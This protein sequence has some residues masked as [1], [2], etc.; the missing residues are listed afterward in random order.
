MKFI[1]LIAILFY[2]GVDFQTKIRPE[3]K[4][5]PFTVTAVPDDLQGAGESYYLTEKDKRDANFICITNYIVALLYVNGKPVRL[6]AKRQLRVSD[7]KNS[8]FNGKYELII[9]NGPEKTD[10]EENYIM[11]ATIILKYNSKVVWMKNVMGEGGD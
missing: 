6:K 4:V 11:K 3:Y 1:L 9:D 2:A 7:K 5:T 10:G 8:Y